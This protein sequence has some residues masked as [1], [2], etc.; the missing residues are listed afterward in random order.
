MTLRVPYYLLAPHILEQ[1]DY[2]ATLPAFPSV[3]SIIATLPLTL[4]AAIQ[5]HSWTT[6]AILAVILVAVQRFIGQ[7]LEPKLMGMRLSLKPVPI[8]L[9]L[10]F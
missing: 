3:G 9:G 2:V 10:I 6:V 7:I 5:L 8:L 4:L 1:R